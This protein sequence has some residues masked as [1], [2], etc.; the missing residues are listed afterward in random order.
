MSLVDHL[1]SFEE[2]L[3]HLESARSYQ[4]HTGRAADLNGDAAELP[5][6]KLAVKAALSEQF[7]V[8]AS[9]HDPAVLQ[10]QNLVG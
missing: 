8:R 4:R 10:H 2:G 7:R 1:G 5:V 6:M 9:L 3:H